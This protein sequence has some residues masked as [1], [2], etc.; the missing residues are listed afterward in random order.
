MLML[1]SSLLAAAGLA[2]GQS[3][4]HRD[5]EPTQRVVYHSPDIKNQRFQIQLPDFSARQALQATLLEALMEVYP[6]ADASTQRGVMRQYE[7]LGRAAW[8]ARH[9][10]LHA[11]TSDDPALQLQGLSTA[12]HLM[13]HDK[14]LQQA[15]RD[16]YEA[17]ATDDSV[18]QAAAKVLAITDPALRRKQLLTAFDLHKD[19]PAEMRKLMDELLFLDADRSAFVPYLIEALDHAD[20]HTQWVIAEI[21]IQLGP[22][23]AEAESTL[24]HLVNPKDDGPPQAIT[25]RN[26]LHFAKAWLAVASEQEKN[27]SELRMMVEHPKTPEALRSGLQELLDKLQEET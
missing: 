13:L 17:E 21:L 4:L 24:E 2:D 27:L 11:V 10:V 26:R 9:Q 22:A 8:P 3:T 16:T 18:R 5:A 1:S 15:I 19:D 7:K 12:K 25:T 6:D 14:T 23:A 20:A